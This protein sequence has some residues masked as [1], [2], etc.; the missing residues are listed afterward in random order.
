MSFPYKH[1]LMIGAT[2][3]IGKAMANRLIQEGVKVTAVGRREG[4]LDEFVTSHGAKKAS[5]EQFDIAD[6]NEIPTF[7]VNVTKRYPDIDCVFLNAGTQAAINLSDPAKWDLNAFQRDVS[8]NFVSF[9]NLT[10][11][12]LPF[13]LSKG[14]TTGL[15]Y[16]TSHLAYIPAAGLSGYSASKA[17]LNSFILC[18]RDQLRNSSVKVVELSPPVVQTELHDYMGARGREMGMP[19]ADFTDA[20]FAGLASGNDEIFIG[21]LSVVSAERLGRI[22]NE[23]RSAFNDLSKMLRGGK[24]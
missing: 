9:V 11:A 16:T 6:S 4:R 8:V 22:V 13:L 23:R 7:A 19:V 5:A 10:H 18:L 24:D 2:A 17:A 15:I 21:D 1:V 20:A 3:G 14:S 12:F